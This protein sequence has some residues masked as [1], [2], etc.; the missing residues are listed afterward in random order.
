LKD[1]ALS[2]GMQKVVMVRRLTDSQ[3]AERTVYLTQQA[4]LIEDELERDR[5]RLER[6]AAARK[7]QVLSEG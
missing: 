4:R 2:Q 7:L 3:I 6:V 1:G 5:T